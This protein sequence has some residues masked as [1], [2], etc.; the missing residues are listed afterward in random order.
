VSFCSHSCR[1]SFNPYISLISLFFFS[2]NI[3]VLSLFHQSQSHLFIDSSSS[4][5]KSLRKISKFFM[6]RM[7]LETIR[8]S[9][10]K[11]SWIRK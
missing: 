3:W 5:L 1:Q 10:H 7:S 4:E 9:Y 11:L 8:Y 2:T 6:S